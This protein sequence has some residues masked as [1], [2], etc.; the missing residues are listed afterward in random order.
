MRF[1]IIDKG[2]SKCINILYYQI[3]L[4]WLFTSNINIDRCMD[5]LS[6]VPYRNVVVLIV[7]IV[8]VV[9]MAEWFP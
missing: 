7:L 1:Y 2:N 5:I 6:T 9:L 8:L 4:G 3:V